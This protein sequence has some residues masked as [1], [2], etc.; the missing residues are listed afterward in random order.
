MFLTILESMKKLLL[1]LFLIS[2][3][4]LA[5]GSKINSLIVQSSG[6]PIEER[7]EIFSSFF[8]GKPTLE[9][10]LGEG[11]TGKFDKDPLY[12]FDGFDCTTFVET[13]LALSHS[14]DF[15]EFE[16]NINLIRYKNGVISFSTRNHFISLDWIP[17]NQSAGFIQDITRSLFT[18][19]TKVSQA[20]INKPNWY[21]KM[22]IGQIQGLNRPGPQL[23]NQLRSLGKNFTPQLTSLDYVAIAL[24]LK[25]L[26][27]I[28]SGSIIN[29]VREGFDLSASIGT[30]LI[31]S[32]QGIAVRKGNKLFYRH[33]TTV[34]P[35]K[36]IDTPLQDYL[37]R[38]IKHSTIKGINILGPR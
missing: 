4:Q 22:K 35:K 15:A 25:H 2:F 24:V 17:N 27:L 11:R 14:L 7:V 19:G 34:G 6:L 16:K 10:P 8:K 28:P 21:F 12:R 37:S 36:V 5:L 18:H 1:A 31:I 13:V 26:E 3:S 23:L 38:Y 32:H 30:S 20:L 9:S 29:I 33:S